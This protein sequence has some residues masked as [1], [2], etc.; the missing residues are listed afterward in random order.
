MLDSAAA[1]ST[2]FGS[3]KKE[4]ILTPCVARYG[5]LTDLRPQNART[6]I[7]AALTAVREADSPRRRRGDIRPSM[8]MQPRLLRRPPSI[9]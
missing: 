6:A 1:A 3:L 4:F 9:R 2:A 5:G 7:I 8:L